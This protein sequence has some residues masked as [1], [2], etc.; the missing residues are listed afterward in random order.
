MTDRPTDPTRR[1]ILKAAA[2]AALPVLARPATPT[3]LRFTRGFPT[4]LAMLVARTGD[5][6]AITR[7]WPAG[8]GWCGRCPES[9]CQ[10][11]GGAC[12]VVAPH[13]LTPAETVTY[14]GRGWEGG[15]S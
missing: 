9:C 4:P 11:S 14:P 8:S 5:T 10:V 15:G 1:D 3:V 12:L 13:D 6:T 2:V 7:V